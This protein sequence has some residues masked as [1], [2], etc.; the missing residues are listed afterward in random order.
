MWYTTNGAPPATPTMQCATGKLEGLHGPTWAPDGESL[1]WGE[2]DGVWIKPGALDC[3]VQPALVIPGASEPD[4]GPAAVG[5]ATR[6]ALKVA[7][8]A[9]RKVKLSVPCATACIVEARLIHKGR[10]IVARRATLAAPGAAKLALKPRKRLARRAKVTVQ[11]TIT[12]SDGA[13]TTLK[14]AVRVR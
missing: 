3:A 7:S 13:A 8:A 2:P 4:W 10:R 1:A 5:A 11:A 14:K 9:R 6:P 12:L